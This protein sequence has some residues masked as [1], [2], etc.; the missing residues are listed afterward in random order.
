MADISL[1]E[2]AVYGI[3]CYS[4]VI[5]LI[6]SA[7]RDTPNT[8]SQSIVRSVWLIPAIFCAA[9]LSGSGVNINMESQGQIITEVYNGTT[10]LLMTN[11]TSYG[12]IPNQIVLVN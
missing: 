1:I 7:F 10:G 8:K 12:T 4:G 11:T 9:I 3:I 5:L 2:F 6:S